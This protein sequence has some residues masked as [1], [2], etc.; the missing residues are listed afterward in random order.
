MTPHIGFKASPKIQ[1]FCIEASR[2][3][4]AVEVLNKVSRRFARDIVHG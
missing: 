1:N 2:G 3:R 4:S